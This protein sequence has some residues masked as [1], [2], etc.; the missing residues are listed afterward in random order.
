LIFPDDLWAQEPG[1]MAAIRRD[2]AVPPTDSQRVTKDGRRIDVSVGASPIRDALGNVVGAST[3]VRDITDRKR[4][5][6]DLVRS[7]LELEQFAYVASH[8]LQE[9]LR[10][11]VNYAELLEARYRD[12]LDDRAKKYIH[13]AVDGARRMQ[14]LVSDLLAYSRVGSQGKP[15]VRVALGPLVQS[16]V[17]SLGVAVR[18]SGAVVETG[19]LPD[20][21]GDEVQLRQLMQNLLTN[22]I[23][24]R[25][26]E[27]PRIVV[28]ASERDGK[29]VVTV[30][31]NGIGFDMKHA[32]R[33]FQMFQRLH[34][35]GAFPGSGIGLAIAKRIVDRHGGLLT[36]DA[37]PGGGA[38]F[39]FTLNPAPAA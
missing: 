5:E 31:D 16:V 39:S 18:E 8:D 23:K 36:V 12:Q 34:P 35:A 9:P 19:P 15:L 37:T 13:F 28:S 14:Q 24:F 10:M 6:A 7:N 27:P 11:V 32:G 22:A 3:I 29:V 30:R 2:E 17:K 20:V 38:T 1:I 21:M 33:I 25:S 26:A 4:L